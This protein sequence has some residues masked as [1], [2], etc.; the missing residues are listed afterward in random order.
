MPPEVVVS[1]APRPL[2][3]Y[4][5]AF[6]VGNLLF[7]AGQLASEFRTGMPAEARINPA[8]PYYGSDIKLLAR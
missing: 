7:A 1:N 5:E 6:A 2:A 4:S 3:S 8:F